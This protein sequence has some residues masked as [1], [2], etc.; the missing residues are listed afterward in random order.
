M[1][2]GLKGADR[3]NGLGPCTVHVSLRP[4]F[5]DEDNVGEVE[6]RPEE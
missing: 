4:E 2:V 6:F 3:G 1:M 5:V